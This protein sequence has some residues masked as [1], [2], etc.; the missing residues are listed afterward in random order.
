MQMQA[1]T[2]EYGLETAVKLAINAGV[3]VLC[4]SNNIQE[5][6]E[7]HGRQS[8]W[9]YSFLVQADESARTHR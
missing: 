6:K 2:N 8:S 9:Y 5:A 4:F 7:V 1:I 3:D